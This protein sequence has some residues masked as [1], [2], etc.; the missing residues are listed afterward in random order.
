MT[1]ARTFLPLLLRPASDRSPREGGGAGSAR[2]PLRAWSVVRRAC[3]EL[4]SYD[5]TG[6]AA[7][8]AFFV[9]LAEFPGLAA[10]MSL[11]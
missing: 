9:L 2:Q 4:F 7:G 5:L 8:V 3:R 11:V 6:T 1:S 10:L